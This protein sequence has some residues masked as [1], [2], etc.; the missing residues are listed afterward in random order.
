MKAV[1][2]HFS[3]EQ[4]SIGALEAGV[5]ALLVCSQTDLREE[6]L[7]KLERASDK[8]L[9]G[10]LRRLVAFKQAFG[11]TPRIVPMTEIGP[12]FASHQALAEELAQPIPVVE[13]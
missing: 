9:E 12:P 13:S 3:V 1:A 4:R 10:P 6:V 8:L 7:S 2:D 5:D 11:S